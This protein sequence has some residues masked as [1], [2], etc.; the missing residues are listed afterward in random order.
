MKLYSLFLAIRHWMTVMLVYN[1]CRWT[2]CEI[3]WTSRRCARAL[4]SDWWMQTQVYLHSPA[5]RYAI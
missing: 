4:C 1:Q 2:G 3:D 5:S